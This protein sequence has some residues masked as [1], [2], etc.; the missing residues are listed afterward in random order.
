[1]ADG[2]SIST[3]IVTLRN[4]QN[5]TVGAGLTVQIN[6]SGSENNLQISNPQTDAGG[7]VVATLSSPF[8]EN[9]VV[10]VIVKGLELELSSHPTIV[11]QIIYQTPDKIAIVS[12]NDQTVVV[13]QV[14]QPLIVRI[15]DTNLQPI[16]NYNVTFVKTIGEG[17]FD[18]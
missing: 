16:F 3:I 7:Q 12:G 11:F 8:A 5:Q 13:N 1:M 14:S 18:G 9:K 10:T 15:L 4:A 2:T 17:S 6:V